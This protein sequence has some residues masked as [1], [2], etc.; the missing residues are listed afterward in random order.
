MDRIATTRGAWWLVLLALGGFCLLRCSRTLGPAHDPPPAGEE[1]PSAA[2][3]PVKDLGAILP[4]APGAREPAASADTAAG[5]PLDPKPSITGEV[6]DRANRPVM[7][8]LCELRPG[9][10]GGGFFEREP[11]VTASAKAT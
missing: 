8:A 1:T 7:G 6:R 10:P 2:P 5:P 3:V 11:S 4:A 9:T